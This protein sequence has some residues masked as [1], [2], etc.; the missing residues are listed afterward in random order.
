[1][2][3]HAESHVQAHT[4]ARF[5]QLVLLSLLADMLA[6]RDMTVAQR[7]KDYEDMQ[8]LSVFLCGFVCVCG[9]SCW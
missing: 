2:P 3:T 1:M 9:R 6:T 7:A 4:H 5:V 8:D